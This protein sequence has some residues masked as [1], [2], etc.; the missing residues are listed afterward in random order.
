[1]TTQRL[2]NANS[3]LYEIRALL[4]APCEETIQDA[5]KRLL[6]ELTNREVVITQKDRALKHITGWYSVAQI[7]KIASEALSLAPSNVKIRLVGA[8]NLIGQVV[9]TTDPELKVKMGTQLYTI[10]KVSE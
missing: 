4:N 7:H 8:V 5:V 9:V 10:E 2:E 1:L 6:D 3:D